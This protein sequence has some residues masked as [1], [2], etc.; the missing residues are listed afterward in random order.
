MYMRKI[1]WMT[2]AVVVCCLSSCYEDKGNYDY[3]LMNDVTVNF[4]MEATEFVMGDVLKIEPQLAFSLGEETNKLAYSWSLNRRQISTDRNLNWMADEE[5][6]YMDL[7]L[8]VTDTETGVSY[9]YAS[10]I[11]ITS[12]Y[13]N[14]AWVVL[15]EKE[16]GTAML[17]YLRPTTKIVPGE[18][19]KEDESVYDCAVTKDVYG[20][21]N[22]G[23]SLG[24][25]PVSISQHFG[26]ISSS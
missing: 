26:T 3:K 16:D 21:S 22:A 9:F 20:I 7:R 17:T 12:P 1:Y 6:K 13:V 18:N 23:S 5:G 4:T 19:G 11:T 2:V 14:S 8:T 24:G 15:S 10:S 25:K